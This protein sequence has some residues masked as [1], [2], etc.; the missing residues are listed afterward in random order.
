MSQDE[1]N[2]G[3]RKIS[4]EILETIAPELKQEY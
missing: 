2:Q 3:K 1:D 4:K